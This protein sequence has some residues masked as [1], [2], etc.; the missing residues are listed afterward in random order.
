MTE[1]FETLVTKCRK[2][3]ASNLDRYPAETIGSLS[4][5]EWEEVVRTKYEMTAPKVKAQKIKGSHLL[6]DG[7][8]TP[9]FADKFIKEM[10]EKNQH[11]QTSVVIDDLVWR[12]CVD[13]KF[14]KGGTSR[15][16]IF[17]EPWNMQVE[18]LK[19]IV[20]EIGDM[21]LKRNISSSD[22]NSSSSSTALPNRRIAAIVQELQIT[23]M[24]VPLLSASG[25][26]KGV[27]KLI[28]RLRAFDAAANDETTNF[29]ELSTELETLLQNWR[30]MASANGV[31]MSASSSKS[32]SNK[33]S[34]SASI[35][36][37]KSRHTSDEQHAEDVIV[38]EKC[39]QWRDL[40]KALVA[41][42][43]KLI[44]S[45]GAKM[46]E[47]R[48]NL[49]VGRPKIS[50][51]KTRNREGKRRTLNESGGF[52]SPSVGAQPRK[53]M[54]LRQDFR[55]QNTKIKG[56]KAYGGTSSARISP[57]P[58]SSFGSSVSSAMTKGGK[59]K[60]QML[61]SSHNKHGR[62]AT[63][64]IARSMIKREVVLQNGKSMKMPK[65]K[66]QKVRRS[67]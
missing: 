53:L 46:R 58:S 54:K 1:P 47:I 63:N 48:K 6:S 36:G 42:E 13:Y 12:D 7:R 28:K 60:A 16:N 52:Q 33:N 25:I 64:G 55:D 62:R 37:G 65:G 44:K 57:I 11:F 67:T 15:P 24:T 30:V 43:Q 27:K 35:S 61:T 39:S 49:E 23:P 31:A 22:G 41:R 4:E 19:S 32:R 17:R 3:I 26:G 40:F 2:I 9:L 50:A 66:M 59:R 8:K 38:I 10:E 14:K 51:A 18:T 34:E 20:Q 29:K 21:S 56:G 5:I 45:H